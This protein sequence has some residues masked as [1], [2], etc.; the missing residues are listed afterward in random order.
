M[1]ER[2]LLFS[3]SKDQGDFR[4]Q[5]YRGTGNGG[6]KKNKTFN[7]CR[8]WCID[9]ETKEVVAMSQCE[10]Q[11]SFEQNKK[12]ALEKLLETEKF[13]VWHKLKVAKKLG[14]LKDIDEYVDKQ[15][16]PENIKIE[17]QIDGKWTE[18]NDM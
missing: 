9:K 15:M 11:R 7:A 6:Q 13:K 3:L 8:I 18:I 14:L 4:I 16:H 10:E 5:A 17:E 12:R 2:K 1:K